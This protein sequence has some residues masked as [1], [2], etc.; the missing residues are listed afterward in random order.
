MARIRPARILLVLVG[1]AAAAGGVGALAFYTIFLRDLPDLRSLRDY[2]PALSSRVFD[3]RGRPIG[4]FYDQRRFLVDLETLPDHAVQAFVAAEDDAFFEH[5]G[6][7]YRGILRAAWRNLMAGKT[8]EGGSTI[9]QQVAK[10]LL[11]SPERRYTRKIKDMLLA[12]RIEQHFSKQEI[13]YLYLNQIYFGNGAYGIGQ[14]ARSYFDVDAAALSISQAALLAGLPKAPSAYSP[15]NNPEAAEARR[16][17]VLRRMVE[18]GTISQAEYDQAL[19]QP[20][21]LRPP[22]TADETVAAYFVEEV[23]RY[24]FEALGGEQVLKG[25]LRVDTTLDLDA[26]RAAV[27]ALRDGL[28]ALDR[29]QGYRGPLRR[30]EPGEI[31]RTLETLAAENGWTAEAPALSGEGP[32]TGIVT[33]VD[34]A[35]KQ[36]TVALAPGVEASVR[37]EDVTWAR[38]PDPARYPTPVRKIEAVLAVGDVARFAAIPAAEGQESPLPERLALHQKPAVQGAL[39]SLDVE[40]GAVLAMVGGYDFGASEFNRATQARR[41]PGSAFKPI[42]YGAAIAQGYTPVSII[43]DRPVVYDDPE[44][45][46]T[47]RPENY[48]RKFLGSLTLRTALARSVNNATIHLLQEVGVGQVIDLARGLGIRSP[49]ERNLSLALGSSGVS[50]L[51]LV[52]AYA[53]FPAGGRIVTPHLIERVAERSGA[54]LMERVPLVDPPTRPPAVATAP[55]LPGGI[56]EV[57]EVSGPP[58]AAADERRVMDPVQAYLVT[59]LLRAVVAEGT[60]RKARSLDRPLAGKTGTTNEQGDAWFVGFSP[61]LATGVWVGHDEKRVLG[62]GE[63][64]GR[65]ALPIWIDFMRDALASYPP[66]DFPVPDGIGFARVDRETGLLA[67]PGSEDSY[68]QAFAVGT[69]PTEYAERGGPTTASDGDRLLRLDAF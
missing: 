47:W 5:Q 48:G 57:A 17:Y 10:S 53:A 23:R 64:G 46:F 60:G 69:E 12:R 67:G 15:V 61:D 24:L 18:V 8:V 37:L 50:L 65:A 4:E 33:A 6:L 29:R 49:L 7:D 21:A 22:D 14:A 27:T 44:S 32:W 28:G 26:Q 43:V 9:T 34:P 1:L 11:L 40:S 63:T 2:R 59:D 25:G 39:L 45:G 42:I 13:L 30:V 62:K 55:S 56:S 68:F 20:P 36:A 19:A 52:R 31:E 38:K 58:D 41:Q 51:E 54:V 66:R 35:Q 16:R 3:R